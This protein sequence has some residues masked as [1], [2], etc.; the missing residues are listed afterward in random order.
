[1]NVPKLQVEVTQSREADA[2]AEAAHVAAALA[3]KI[4]AQEAVAARDSAA[5]LLKDAKDRATLVERKAREMVSRVEVENAT[6]LASAHEDAEGLAWKIALLK[7][8][9]VEVR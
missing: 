2:D 8:K 4:S 5:I 3:A 7:G 1:V 6:A 9:V